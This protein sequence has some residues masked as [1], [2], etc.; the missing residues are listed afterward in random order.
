M[1]FHKEFWV[2]FKYLHRFFGFMLNLAISATVMIISVLVLAV[3]IIPAI[4]IFAQQPDD[5]GF[6]DN[7]TGG[8]GTPAVQCGESEEL[9]NDVCRPI[10][11][12]VTCTLG[13]VLVNDVCQEQGPLIS[14]QCP[15][16][17]VLVNDVCQSP[18]SVE[19]GGD[20][21]SFF[22]LPDRAS[23]EPVADI[24]PLIVVA[25][26]IVIGGIALGKYS[27]NRGRGRRIKIPPSAVVDIHT[28]GGRNQ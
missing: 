8:G 19:P 14:T 25:S 13:Q 10:S 20:V 3:C 9:V 23:A 5:S 4:T 1:N 6:P 22:N 24:L 27:K 21:L 2:R 18:Q 16:G 7:A 15:E 12:E 11:R 17:Q 28:K 26:I